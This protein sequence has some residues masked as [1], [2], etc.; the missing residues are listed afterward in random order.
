V[1]EEEIRV[2]AGTPGYMAPEVFQKLP[3]GKPVDMWSIGVLSYLLLSGGLPFES[4]DSPVDV[5]KILKA[6]FYFDENYW[7]FISENAKSFISSLLVLDPSKRLTAA[8]ALNHPWF[9][10]TLH[11]QKQDLLPSCQKGFNARKVFRRAIDVVKAVNKLSLSRKSSHAS[12][13]GRG[14]VGSVNFKV[15]GV[16]Q[17]HSPQPM[18][19]LGSLSNLF[20]NDAK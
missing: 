18:S 16:E 6:E 20:T 4:E 2:S 17:T 11:E 19:N 14:S 5:D 13:L 1:D 8:Q 9:Q 3:H 15:E 7:S 10:D 12:S